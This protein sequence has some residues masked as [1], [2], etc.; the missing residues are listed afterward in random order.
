MPHRKCSIANW[1]V[2]ATDFNSRKKRLVPFEQMT[3]NANSSHWLSNCFTY[4]SFPFSLIGKRWILWNWLR[5]S[6]RLWC[7]RWRLGDCTWIQVSTKW[8]R[9]SWLT[10][11]LGV[12]VMVLR[13]IW[14]LLTFYNI[15]EMCV[16]CGSKN[17]EQ[18]TATNSIFEI[19]HSDMP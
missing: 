10:L 19:L 17:V 8:R 16:L 9:S 14:G 1:R 6:I 2:T 15:Y 18:M 12:T 4:T 11:Y 13:Y 7:A 5:L 3:H